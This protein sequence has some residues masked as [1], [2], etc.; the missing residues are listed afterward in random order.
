MS[1]PSYGD[2]LPQIPNLTAD[3]SSSEVSSLLGF[4]SLDQTDVNCCLESI[5]P[6]FDD[7][8][9][10]G[11]GSTPSLA[12]DSGIGLNS[13]SD[14]NSGRDFRQMSV[15]W[16]DRA[17]LMSNGIGGKDISNYSLPQAPVEGTMSPGFFALTH[18]FNMQNDTQTMSESI[19]S[20]PFS[21]TGQST[22]TIELPKQRR[23]SSSCDC[24]T[25]CCD[26]LDKMAAFKADSSSHPSSNRP[27]VFEDVMDQNDS[28]IETVREILECAC[29]N[30]NSSLYML[31][32]VVFE[33]L[34]W[35]AATALA[36]KSSKKSENLSIASP[37]AQLRAIV[38][39]PPSATTRAGDADTDGGV[40]KEHMIYQN[41]ITKLY[42][43]RRVGTTL[44]KRLLAA[45]QKSKIKANA[46][47]SLSSST[48]NTS[49][50]RLA[51]A[52]QSILVYGDM[53]PSSSAGLQA[54]GIWK[55]LEV[56]LRTRLKEVSQ[57]IVEAL[58]EA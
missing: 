54:D 25:K 26:L 32:Y 50:G 3:F 8:I 27:P 47:K 20:D 28:T 31:C 12:G 58:R 10:D 36:V 52:A 42:C 18:I 40:Y 7:L 55:S 15:G 45:E 21:T 34:G 57:G 17:T 11:H 2:I 41:M 39:Q 53:F 19:S 48:N 1:P 35:Y 4:S 51:A 22:H 56:G 24:R 33:T 30:N 49:E 43:V 37:D 29:S 13:E 9:T 5:G 44:S 14:I 16:E 38:V 6:P 23:K 46:K